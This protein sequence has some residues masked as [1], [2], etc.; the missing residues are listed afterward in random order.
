MVYP[1]VT[2]TLHRLTTMRWQ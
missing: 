1:Y 2:L